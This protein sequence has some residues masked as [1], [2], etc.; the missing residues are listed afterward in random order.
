MCLFVAEL[1]QLFDVK[2]ERI[3]NYFKC[4]SNAKAD[5]YV[6]LLQNGENWIGNLQFVKR[7]IQHC[8]C[9]LFMLLADEKSLKSMSWWIQINS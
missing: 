7:G 9:H 3:S 2:T 5:S 8:S 1:R 6:I 4:V